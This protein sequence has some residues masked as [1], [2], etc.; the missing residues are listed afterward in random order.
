MTSAIYASLGALLIVW[1]SLRVIKLRHRERVSLGDG[2]NEELRGAIAAQANAV[3]YIP[4]GL[5][6][7][8][9]LEYNHAPL[10]LVHALGITLLTG[11][12]V[13]AYALLGTQLE[14]RVRGMQIT[15]WTII[16]LA[17]ANLGYLPYGDLLPR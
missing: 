3:E 6:L 14:L 8:F 5:L 16:V 12:A 9:A 13:H 11:R 2:G 15:L 17:L 1:L 4:I 10:L 7:L